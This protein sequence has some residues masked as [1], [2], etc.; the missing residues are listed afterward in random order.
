[1]SFAGPQARRRCPPCTSG[2]ALLAPAGVGLADR[3]ERT[4][5]PL[6]DRPLDVLTAGAA[7]PCVLG[8]PHG[9]GNPA[10]PERRVELLLVD[11][12]GHLPRPRGKLEFSMA[13]RWYQATRSIMKQKAIVSIQLSNGT[14]NASS[15]CSPIRRRRRSSASATPS[16]PNARRSR[17]SMNPW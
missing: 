8:I 6:V 17:Q 12:G 10:R 16:G 4:R 5:V 7:E 2:A 15:G 9:V 14:L 3:V 13:R 1:M 11:H